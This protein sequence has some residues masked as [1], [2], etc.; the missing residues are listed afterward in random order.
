MPDASSKRASRALLYRRPSRVA[1]PPDFI[2]AANFPS[3]VYRDQELACARWVGGAP[4]PGGARRTGAGARSGVA[5]RNPAHSLCRG[6]ASRTMASTRCTARIDKLA[7]HGSAHRVRD[8]RQRRLV[9]RLERRGV[10]AGSDRCWSL[11][12][13][14]TSTCCPDGPGPPKRLLRRLAHVGARRLVEQLQT[15]RCP[16]P[17]AHDVRRRC[18][19]R[20]SRPR[21][22]TTSPVCVCAFCS[23]CSGS[24]RVSGPT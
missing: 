10:R 2:G 14:R 12:A 9:E 23:H 3:L 19:S 22:P 16:T 21:P 17:P 15:W 18:A 24:G 13:R 8:R 1:S 20:S 4:C 6:T 7:V 5:L 11:S